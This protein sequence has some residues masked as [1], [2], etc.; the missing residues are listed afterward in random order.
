[1][2]AGQT[3]TLNANA[4]ATSYLWNTGETTASIT[5][6]M[7]GQFWVEQVSG[8]CSQFDTIEVF[9]DNCNG[10]PVIPNNATDGT[11]FIPNSFSPN[12]DGTND[13]F[14]AVGENISD[15]E[16]SIFDRWGERIFLSA[17]IYDHWDGT[18]RQHKVEQGVY[19]YKLSYKNNARYVYTTGHV[20]LIR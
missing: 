19:V 6:N 4:G 8:S 3:I 9:N 1:M 11:L 13:S 10:N 17:S 12:G 15:F 2:C 18:Y 20:V 16:I 5:V 14:G 7:A